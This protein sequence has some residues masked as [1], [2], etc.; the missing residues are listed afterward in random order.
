MN[1]AHPRFLNRISAQMAILILA[2]LLAIHFVITAGIFLSHRMGSVNA[3]DEDPARFVSLVRLIAGAP[4]DQ[5]AR[6][7]AQ[8]ARSFPD[9]QM[10]TAASIPASRDG[11][12]A[13][14]EF[15]FI[16]RH[17][18]PGF[19]VTS[20]PAVVQ[21]GD[22]AATHDVAVRLPDGAGLIARLS[23]NSRLPFLGGPIM[24]TVLF[25]VISVTLLALWATRA[26]GTP[27]SRFAKAADG[28][29]LESE[30]S[31]LPERGP[32]EI[33]VVAKAFNRMRGRIKRLVDD[34]TRMFA[35]LG[36]DLRTPITRLRLRSEFI[37]DEELR[38]QM[39]SD[40]D[41]MRAMT[42][43]VLSF[44][45]DEKNREPATVMDLASTLQTVCNQFADLGH[46]VRYDGSAHVTVTAR[47]G[48]LQRAVAN[49]VDN[50]VRYGASTT[51]RLAEGPDGVRIEV[52]DDGPGI[53]DERKDAM[54][55]AFV[56]GEPARTMDGRAGFGLGLSIARSVA[57]AHGGNLTLR[58][59]TPHGLIACIELPRRAA[60]TK[61]VA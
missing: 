57:E 7:I 18:G 35:A 56:R 38:A 37:A 41:Q 40:L 30:V 43:D 13:G 45:R 25:V 27:L 61:S 53:A 23:P 15:N 51:V 5:R 34:R 1:I 16:E 31:D 33:R 17:L 55:E 29:D 36:H 24:L 49:L 22:G 54:L 4:P 46:A 20:A 8:V 19:H 21:S 39:L 28:F 44:L 58:D 52:E 12:P 32:D 59:R 11:D 48:D 26:L 10:K 14:G 50:A 60:V 47:P 2:S 6:L 3:F 42:D 9:L